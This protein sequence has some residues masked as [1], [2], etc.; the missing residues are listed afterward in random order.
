MLVY[1]FHPQ[2][3]EL[4]GQDVADPS[5]LEPGI[6]LVPAGATSATPPAPQAGKARVWNGSAWTLKPDHRGETWYGG[7]DGRQPTTISALGDPAAD[8]LAPQP[9][10]KTPEELK[11]DL[12]V[13]YT[14][15]RAH[16]T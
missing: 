4:V 7:A 13:S 14:H 1:S 16:E 11:A 2:T 12:P 15:L 8:G 5:P 10:P 6:W 3:G 9:A